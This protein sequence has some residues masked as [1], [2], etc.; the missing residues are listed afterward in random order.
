MSANKCNYSKRYWPLVEAK[1]QSLG[2]IRGGE[3]AE[4]KLWMTEMFENG[5]QVY[6]N[7]AS[8]V[9][10]NS[11]GSSFSARTNVNGR[12]QILTTETSS[13]NGFYTA[14]PSAQ[15]IM[16]RRFKRDIVGLSIIRLSDDGSE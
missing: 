10:S 2:Y 12:G 3:N 8:G 13:I 11:T 16:E 6:E 5:E 1:M 9:I 7:I 4:L 15:R 14:N